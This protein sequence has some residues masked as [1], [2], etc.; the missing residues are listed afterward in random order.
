ME[1]GAARGVNSLTVD[2]PYKPIMV[3]ATTIMVGVEDMATVQEEGEAM[4]EQVALP[5]IMAEQAPKALCI[6]NASLDRLYN[7]MKRRHF[8]AHCHLVFS[9]RQS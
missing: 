7:P 1:A 6:S 2:A 3:L 9:L 5:T 8:Y 4:V